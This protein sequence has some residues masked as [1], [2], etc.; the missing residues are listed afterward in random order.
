MDP[1]CSGFVA[2]AATTERSIPP[3]AMDLF[4]PSSV[5][6]ELAL[7]PDRSQT[8]ETVLCATRSGQ[9]WVWK[10]IFTV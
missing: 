1:T 2:T 3:A 9:T 4:N 8:A 5:P 6:S 7:I 10:S